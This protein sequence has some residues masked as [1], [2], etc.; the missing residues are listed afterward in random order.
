MFFLL[1]HSVLQLLI[2]PP[3]NK[4][5]PDMQW[6]CQAKE[7]QSYMH[8]YNTIIN[9]KPCVIGVKFQFVLEDFFDF[10]KSS[11]RSTN[12]WLE[13]DPS[14]VVRVNTSAN[15]HSTQSTCD[16]DGNI[17]SFGKVKRYTVKCYGNPYWRK[18]FQWILEKNKSAGGARGEQ[19]NGNPSRPKDGRPTTRQHCFP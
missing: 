18:I 13:P 7:I 11:L 10:V 2:T 6:R 8:T 16:A 1:R 12:L 9:L 3:E 5:F 4:E 14:H 19:N 15:Y 17:V